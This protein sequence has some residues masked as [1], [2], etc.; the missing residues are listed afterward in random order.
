MTFI[1]SREA[2]DRPQRTIQAM[3]V[4]QAEVHTIAERCATAA[5]GDVI[6][7]VVMR[8]LTFGG[9]WVVATADTTMVLEAVEDGGWSL[10]FPRHASIEHIQHQ[11]QT[12]ADIAGK[13]LTAIQRWLS[14]HS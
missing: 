13:R 4:F 7:A 5:E 1:L 9:T 6:V 10:S 3:Q 2:V 8:D 14:R 11:C 12:V